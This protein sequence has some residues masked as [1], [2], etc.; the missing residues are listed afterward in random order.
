VLEHAAQVFRDVV[1]P[2]AQLGYA[3][4]T[5]PVA[6]P[7]IAGTLPSMGVLPAIKLDREG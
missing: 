6:A 7:L 4:F 5:Q 3:A 1:V 2:E